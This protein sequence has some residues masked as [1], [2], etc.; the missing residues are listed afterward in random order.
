MKKCFAVLMLS[1]LCLVPNAE[2]KTIDHFYSSASDNVELNG[3]VNGS[4]ALAGDNV[5]IKSKVAG[6][7]FGAGDDVTL[8]GQ[9]DYAA[10]AGR[11]VTI[12]G[13][14]NNDA[15]LAGDTI[16]INKD[17]IIERD[18]VIAGNE[19]VIAGK[20]NRNISIYA[21]S[22]VIQKGAEINGNVKLEVGSVT[23][24][25]DVKIKGE[26]LYPADAKN[27]ISKKA[28]IG[29][30]V[31]TESLDEGYSWTNV[32]F[33]GLM[34]LLMLLVVF[35]VLTLVCPKVFT[36]MQKKYDKFNFDKGFELT[37]KG[38]LTLIFVPIICVLGFSLAI[39]ASLSLILLALYV[40]AIYLSTIFVGYLIGYKIWQKYSKKDVNILVI[41][42]LGM[43]II[44]ILKFIPGVNILVTI[45]TVLIGMGIIVDVFKPEKD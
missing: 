37:T 39:G 28:T 42:L 10:L 4:S 7:A 14:V 21:S 44:T 11:E 2:A 27:E 8:D 45:L 35:A 41:G 25:D 29:S 33:E 16:K 36:K 34:S 38:L 23:V 15:F 24:L 43:M 13:K 18:T 31:K 3:N 12:N 6:I 9:S 20:I 19:V 17:A 40:I 26:L 1:I 5:V 30:L 22:V 32:F